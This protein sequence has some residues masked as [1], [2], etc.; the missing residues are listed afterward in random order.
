MNNNIVKESTLNPMLHEIQ[1]YPFVSKKPNRKTGALI[2]TVSDLNGKI[3]QCISTKTG[4]RIIKLI[5]TPIF[6]SKK[7]R[8]ESICDFYKNGINQELI[9]CAHGT[10]QSNVSNILKKSKNN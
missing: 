9:A 1:E 6:N 7:E 3:A 5:D 8:D 4:G 10:S 2:E